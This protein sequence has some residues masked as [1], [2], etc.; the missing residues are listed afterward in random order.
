MYTDDEIKRLIAAACS[1]RDRAIIATAADS[2]A[3]IHEIAVLTLGDLDFG[4]GGALVTLTGHKTKKKRPTWLSM[5]RGPISHSG[6][7]R[8]PMVLARGYR[9]R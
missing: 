8:S 7:H 6:A 3:R 1:P 5:A 4:D 9:I 2:S